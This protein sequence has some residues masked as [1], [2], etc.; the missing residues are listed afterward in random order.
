MNLNQ[1]IS[2]DGAHSSKLI[3]KVATA[4]MEAYSNFMCSGINDLQGYSW[5]A[6]L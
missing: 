5:E 2:T 3:T 4:L 1:N 6:A